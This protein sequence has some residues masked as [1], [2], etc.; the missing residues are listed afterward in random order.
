MDYGADYGAL[1][2]GVLHIMRALFICQIDLH[3]GAL[4]DGVLHISAL[5]ICYKWTLHN[6]LRSTI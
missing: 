2:D 4:H 5:F 3:H 1:H 6:P